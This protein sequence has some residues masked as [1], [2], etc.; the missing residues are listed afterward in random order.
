MTRR[1]F[2]HMLGV[3]AGVAV[4]TPA[5]SDRIRILPE[6]RAGEPAVGGDRVGPELRRFLDGVRVGERRT[7]GGLTV[8]WLHA[9]RGAAPF[10]VRTLDEARAGADLVVTERDQATVPG[11]VIDNRGPEHVLLL[12]G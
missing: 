2:L 6:V 10:A 8:F 12:A 1:G 11:L 3:G 9:A 7:H 4:A 5:R